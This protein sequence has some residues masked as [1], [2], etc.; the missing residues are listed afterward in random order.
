MGFREIDLSMILVSRGGTL[1]SKGIF[2]EI[3]ES[4]SR[5]GENLGREIGRTRASL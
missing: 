2:R 4:A 1:M 5:S 3:R